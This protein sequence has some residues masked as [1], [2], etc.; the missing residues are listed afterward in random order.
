MPGIN[1]Y[2]LGLEL[3]LQT[4][5]DTILGGLQQQLTQLQVQ[6]SEGLSRAFA[7]STQPLAAVNM[8]I[9][10]ATKF[11]DEL[12][13]KTAQ[14][15]DTTAYEAIDGVID[16]V[17][18]HLEDMHGKYITF[19]DRE[20]AQYKDIN[21]YMAEGGKTRKDAITQLKK[22]ED[23]LEKRV[24]TFKGFKTF[25]V[26]QLKGLESRLTN[27]RRLAKGYERQEKVQQS[28]AEFMQ[29]Q[30]GISADLTKGAIL[31]S[32]AIGILKTAIMEI[33]GTQEEF[34]TANIAAYGG[35]NEMTEVIGRIQS[36]T[37]ATTPEIL[38]ASQALI[39]LGARA[40]DIEALTK[41]NV[42]FARTTGVSEQ[43]TAEFQKRLELMGASAGE[44][45]ENLSVLTTLQARFGLSSIQTSKMMTVLSKNMARLKAVYGFGA[46]ATKEFTGTVM[47]LAGAAKDSGLRM[48]EV[49]DLVDRLTNNAMEFV[50]ALGS[51]ALYQAPEQNLRDLA[52]RAPEILA[53]VEKVPLALQQEISKILG[54]TSKQML[55]TLAGFEGDLSKFDKWMGE[56]KT[57]ENFEK[58]WG[59]SMQTL[60]RAFLQVVPALVSLLKVFTP[61]VP[62]IALIGKGI[63]FI[64]SP[65]RKL[66]EGFNWLDTEAGILGKTIAIL[67][68]ILATAGVIWAVTFGIAFLP[69]LK[70]VAA[71]ALMVAV[72]KGLWSLLNSTSKSLQWLGVAL[73]VIA[74]PI[75][76]LVLAFKAASYAVSGFLEGFRDTFGII[77]TVVMDA[78]QPIFAAFDDLG[79]AIKKLLGITDAKGLVGPW[80]LLKQVFKEVGCVMRPIIVVMI[81]LL[82]NYLKPA[83]MAIVAVIKGLIAVVDWLSDALVGHSLVP[84][85]EALRDIVVAVA[86]PIVELV[87]IMASAFSPIRILEMLFGGVVGIL[88]AL[89]GL[90]TTVGRNMVQVFDSFANAIERLRGADLV[91]MGGGM[92]Q[93]AKGTAAAALALV[94]WRFLGGSISKVERLAFSVRYLASSVA[95]IVML[96]T[97][98]A[99][100]GANVDKLGDSV[101]DLEGL[102]TKAIETRAHS[103]VD[104]KIKEDQ[105][106]VGAEIEDRRAL[107]E[108]MSV[109]VD[110]MSDQNER[111]EAIVE[112]TARMARVL[113]ENLPEMT[114]NIA[115]TTVRNAGGRVNNWG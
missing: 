59:E 100:L 75:G 40:S 53:Q 11:Y 23:N 85:L 10:D 64:L 72:V 24:K 35:M 67:G 104:V 26:E 82:V 90:I 91:G 60:K 78:L 71:I 28:I 42:Q 18:I 99:T 109:L 49:T 113:E 101:G 61:L 108:K 20:I 29:K 114:D 13:V 33:I 5:A 115:S 110:V 15:P 22:I 38:A 31:Q 37:H 84:A 58:Q 21:K 6:A 69:I 94:G 17:G 55:Q 92:Y 32:A 111:N 76:W 1:E 12:Q 47:A 103:I 44:V 4:N 36:E 80:E 65:L 34:H 98:M 27:V 30:L 19:L 63:V 93:L 16:Q 48:E 74:G 105:G 77:K 51:K 3:Q 9:Q 70:F 14:T 79:V 39:T 97:A 95:G 83:I 112:N 106:R 43:A 96:S 56:Q 50:V 52:K 107:I 68:K 62:I 46:K 81:K 25:D 54:G 102:G 88:E 86:S 73:A 7:T 45:F 87:R 41:M 8:Q 66:A 57:A 89:G 2:A